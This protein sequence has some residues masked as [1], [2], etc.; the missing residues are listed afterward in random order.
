MGWFNYPIFLKPRSFWTDPYN[1][2]TVLASEI[3]E[4]KYEQV[5]VRKVA[6][7]QH[8]LTQQQCQE[9]ALVLQQYPDLFS[10]KLGLYPYRK[11]HF[12]LVD[13]TQPIHLCATHSSTAF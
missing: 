1:I 7:Q 12:D 4:S 11:I 13:G 9:L 2:H 5:S 8:H 6:L 3:Q 10:G